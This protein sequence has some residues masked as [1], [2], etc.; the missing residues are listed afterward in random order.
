MPIQIYGLDGRYASALY[1]AAVKKSNLEATEQEIKT[2]KALFNDHK[3]FHDFVLDPTIK[4]R[5][6]KAALQEILKKLGCSEAAQNFFAI[7]ADN[8]RLGKIESIFKAFEKLMSAHRGEVA[9]E[10]V[11]AT[12]I[13]EATLKEV[14]AALQGFIKSNQKL[15]ISTKIDPLLLGGMVVSIGDKYVDMS[16]AT[17]IK[18]FTKIIE[19]AL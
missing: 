10:I 18:Q 4:R 17:K 6:K 19:E 7:V 12:P 2:V 13:D 1:S 3:K 16:V 9:C 8:G 11:T 5:E 14:T 15:Q